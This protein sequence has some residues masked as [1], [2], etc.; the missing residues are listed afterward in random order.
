VLTDGRLRL[1]YSGKICLEK[2]FGNFIG[3]LK[4][5]N[6]YNR[7]LNI[8][9][10]IIGWY[11]S[12]RDKKDCESLIQSVKD[13]IA[14][15]FYDRQ[16]FTAYLELIND[17]DIFLDLRADSLENRHSLPIKLF[18]YA[19][20]GRPVIFSDLK[21]IRREVE[22]ESFGFLVKPDKPYQIVQVISQYLQNKQHYYNHC[23][24]ARRMA[25]EYYNWQKVSQE[26]L[27]FIDTQ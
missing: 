2:G 19:A 17:T 21:A 16:P 3:V 9:V 24:N 22:T 23:R 25:E 10:K 11:E 6:R 26:F 7:Y 1:C 18:Y 15:S 27:T 8:E 13:N 4:E 5:L 12:S 20:L 14:F